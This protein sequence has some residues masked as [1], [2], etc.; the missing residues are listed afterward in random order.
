MTIDAYEHV[1]RGGTHMRNISEVGSTSG[2]VEPSRGVLKS[3]HD[4][5]G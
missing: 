2:G 4:V 3:Y 5:G 1:S